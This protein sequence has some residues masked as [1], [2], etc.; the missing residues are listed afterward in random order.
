MYLNEPYTQ[1]HTDRIDL[2]FKTTSQKNRH[3]NTNSIFII[4]IRIHSVQCLHVPSQLHTLLLNVKCTIRHTLTRHRHFFLARAQTVCC[5]CW[6]M[7]WAKNWLSICASCWSTEFD[8]RHILIWQHWTKNA[9]SNSIRCV[10]ICVDS[11]ALWIL[12]L[13]VSLSLYLICCYLNYVLPF[14]RTLRLLISTCFRFFFFIFTCSWHF[15]LYELNFFFCYIQ[16]NNN[17]TSTFLLQ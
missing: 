9:V 14:F 2:Q 17:Q 16:I 13:S 4:G 8:R 3:N 6:V 10:L 15:V 1:P 11:F 7:H 5:R 12:F